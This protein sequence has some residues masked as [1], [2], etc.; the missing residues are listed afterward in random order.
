MEPQRQVDQRI[1]F[2]LS[3]KNA[4]KIVCLRIEASADCA[5]HLSDSCNTNQ[6]LIALS[7]EPFTYQLSFMKGWIFDMVS[8]QL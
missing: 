1:F 7:D 6:P 8:Q 3:S 4:R 5:E 2:L